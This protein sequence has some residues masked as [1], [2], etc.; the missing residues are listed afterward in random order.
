MMASSVGLSDVANVLLSKKG[1]EINAVDKGL[2]LTAL[3]YAARA[4]TLDTGKPRSINTVFAL[5]VQ[6]GADVTI[7]NKH[8][9]TALELLP[10]LERELVMKSTPKTSELETLQR[11]YAAVNVK[12]NSSTADLDKARWIIREVRQKMNTKLAKLKKKKAGPILAGRR[13]RRN[14]AF[15][16]NVFYGAYGQ[17]T[18]SA[19]KDT[20]ELAREDVASCLDILLEIRIGALDPNQQQMFGGM[21]AME[22]LPE[23][24]SDDEGSD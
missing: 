8:G 5:L 16:M 10:P 2:G 13:G 3:H 1:V 18:E 12:I 15:G 19:E 7:K 21:G 23:Y 17:Q 4:F 20:I 6:A 24:D 22:M 14:Q 11:I 9:R